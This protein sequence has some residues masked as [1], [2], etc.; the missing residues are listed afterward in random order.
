MFGSRL[1]LEHP[2]DRMGTV[3][4]TRVRRW[5]AGVAAVSLG[6]AAAAVGAHGGNPEAVPARQQAY[7]VKPGDTLWAIATRV[8]GR[9]EDPRMLI[10][11]ITRANELGGSLVPGQTLVIPT[12]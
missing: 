5:R 8:G 7:V 12:S 9:A 3:D 11:A 1:D 10:A 6:L 2:F 4:R